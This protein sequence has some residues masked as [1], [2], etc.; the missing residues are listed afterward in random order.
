ML[1]YKNNIDI[2]C[3]MHISLFHEN[4]LF[5]LEPS[6]VCLDRILFIYLYLDTCYL[7]ICY[8]DIWYLDICYL[9]ICYLDI[10]YFDKQSK[11]M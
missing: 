9:D 11:L 10:W 2:V 7:D 6:E 3:A 1:F 4:T 8:L 5:H